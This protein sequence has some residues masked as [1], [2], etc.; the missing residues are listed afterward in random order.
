M[1][2]RQSAGTKIIRQRNDTISDSRISGGKTMHNCPTCG[3]E[4]PNSAR[5]CRQCGVALSGEQVATEA[6]TRNFGRQEA[7]P[8]VSAPLPPSVADAVSGSTA[9]YPQP[10]QAPPNYAPP[11]RNAFAP[12]TAS[13]KSKPRRLKWAGFILALLISGGIGAAIN[14][15]ANDDKVRLSQAD[16][17]RL[18]QLRKEDEIAGLAISAV[19]EQRR[20]LSRELDQRLEEIQDARRDAERAARKGRT[21]ASDE[22]PLNLSEY[23]YPGA[24]SSQSS[25][26][27]GKELLTQRTKDDLEEI[28]GFY[29]QKLGKPYVQVADKKILFQSAGSPAVSVLIQESRERGRQW[30]IITLRSPFRF[31]QLQTE[32][33]APQ[34]EK[35][36][37]APDKTEQKT[38][39]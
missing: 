27:P 33:P 29:Q 12:D 37:P 32:Q 8:A 6:T 7:A 25:L 11:A 1:L 3:F 16:R 39:P 34:V 14:D 36:P 2:M 15:E 22:A 4:S 13:L 28:S 9:R 26:I 19:E 20:R 35:P 23:E 24:T 21:V 10:A 5:F 18:E 30:E 31:P 17:A 38:T